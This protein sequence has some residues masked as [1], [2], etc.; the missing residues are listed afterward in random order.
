MAAR[1][2]GGKGGGG[3]S[4]GLP[5]P[6]RY[7]KNKNNGELQLLKNGVAISK[8]NEEG[9]WFSQSV[10]T[11]TGSF[12]LGGLHSNGSA[13][14]NVVWVNNDSGFAYFPPWQGVSL[15]G[16]T[17]LTPTVRTFGSIA[18][19]EPNGPVGA[20]VVS[21]DFNLTVSSDVAFFKI[22]ILPAESYDGQ[23]HWRALNEDGTEV[24]SFVFDVNLTAGTYFTMTLKYPLFAKQ[25]QTFRVIGRKGM[26]GGLLQVRSGSAN[27]ATPYRRTVTRSFTDVAVPSMGATL[28]DVKDSVKTADHDGW[29]L[30]NG[31]AKNTLTSLQQAAC[32]LLGIGANLPDA[33]NRFRVGAG[34]SYTNMSTGGSNMI[35]RNQLPNVTIGIT[36]LRTGNQ[37]QNHNHQIDPPNAYTGAGSAHRHGDGTLATG[38]ESGHQ[39]LENSQTSTNSVWLD[40]GDDRTGVYSW[41][42]MGN[43]WSGQSSGHTHD[44][45]G[46]TGDES[47]HTHQVNIPEFTSGTNNQNHDHTINGNT[48]S[49]NGGVSQNTFLPQYLAV[50]AFI[51]L[52]NQ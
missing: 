29:I 18:T 36:N 19:T 5:S 10:S 20:D 39:H 45:T 35:S 40:G 32:N 31:R 47:S 14:E 7:V 44:V 25:S 11:S 43:T 49:L 12:H 2:N 28:G 23:Y 27:A 16:A 26:Q 33:R 38:A 3:G 1:P 13:G 48:D 34:S 50:N 24:A 41:P 17:V 46:Q 22:T 37:N 6:Y 21:Y 52:G 4:G 30:L 9:S 8:Q 42:V 51:Y 15:D